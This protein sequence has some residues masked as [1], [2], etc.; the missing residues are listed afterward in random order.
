MKDLS[1]IS[2][3][4]IMTKIIMGACVLHNF[5]LIHDDFDESYFLMMM[6]MMMM[7]MTMM[8]MSMIATA[9]TEQLN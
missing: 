2:A 9:E 1:F 5:T 8:M 7:M 4:Y 3:R 6:M